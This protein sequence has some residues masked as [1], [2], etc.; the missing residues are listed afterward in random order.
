VFK[1]YANFTRSKG[2]N[3]APETWLES[4]LLWD[5]GSLAGSPKTYYAGV[6]YQYIHNKFGNQ[7]TLAGTK[8]SAPELKLEVHF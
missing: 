2:K 6:G 5:V 7:S 8:V 3:T 4:S 1:G